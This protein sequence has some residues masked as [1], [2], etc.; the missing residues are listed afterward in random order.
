[1]DRGARS[2]QNDSA[3]LKSRS[4]SMC[5]G[6]QTKTIGIFPF[7]RKRKNAMAGL[8]AELSALVRPLFTDMH[9][10]TL[11]ESILPFDRASKV[12]NPLLVCYQQ[13][14]RILEMK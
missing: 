8:E 10:V 4:Q 13:R 14:Q 2:S 1:M 7:P 9:T 6:T 5:S 12:L 11:H 3:I